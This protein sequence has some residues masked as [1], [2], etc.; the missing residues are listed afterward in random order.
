MK[1]SARFLALLV[2]SLAA[3]RARADGPHIAYH[4]ETGPYSVT[5]FSAPD[6]LVAGPVELVLLVQNSADGAVVRDIA[7]S[8]TLRMAG[9]A[10][11]PV[12][13]RP[14][15]GGNPKLPGASVRVPAAGKWNMRLHLA[16]PG[17]ASIDCDVPLPV[18]VNH[19]NRD[20]VLWAVF[21]LGAT[22]GLFLA[23]QQGKAKLR[24]RK[25]HA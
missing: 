24:A 11:I 15:A 13:L 18:A 8:A 1:R 12:A 6:P 9:Q 3:C 19:G 2:L 17:R 22:I 4:A 10:P 25:A 20:T 14:G 7:A 23:N 16:P 5:V 21:L